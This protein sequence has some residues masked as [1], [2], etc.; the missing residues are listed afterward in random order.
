MFLVYMSI[1][2]YIAVKFSNYGLFFF[3]SLFLVSYTPEKQSTTLDGS[4]GFR[5]MPQLS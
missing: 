4:L 2:G 5:T 3:F 1:R